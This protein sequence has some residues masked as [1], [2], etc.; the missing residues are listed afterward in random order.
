M[1]RYL[2]VAAV[3]AI[4]AALVSG[5]IQTMVSAYAVQ[6]EWIPP[7]SGIYTGPQFSQ[8]IGDAFRSVASGNKGS[9]APATV[10]G[11]AVDGLPWID[12]TTSFWLKK[13][14]INGGWATEGAY[15]SAGSAWVG[16]IGGGAPASIASSSTVDLGS[17][18]QANVGITGTA[19]ITGFG[20]SAA[21]GI[22]KI[23]R[24]SGALT[25]TNSGS[26]AIPGG[27][28]LVTAAGDRAIVTHLGSGN[29]EIT[30]YTRANGI[31]VD[32]SAVGKIEYGIFESVPANHVAGY[33]QA[34]SR[35]AYPAYVAKVT[36]T[37]TVTRSTGSPS[38]S[39]SLLDGL[40]V[41]MPIEGVGIP[42]GTTIASIGPGTI[43]MSANATSPGS[44][45]ATV[46]L[47]GY[48]S[49]GS[50][51]TV[52]APDCRGRVMAGRDRNDPGSFAN[53]L[54]SSYFGGDSSIF[55]VTGASL[56]S[57]TMAPG[58]L[59][60][61]T[62]A[63]TLTDPGHTHN[64]GGTGVATWRL[65]NLESNA[66][67]PSNSIQFNNGTDGSVAIAGAFTGLTI[68]NAV[69]GS[70]SPT[71]MRTVQPTLIAECVIR[72]TP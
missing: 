37:Q 4:S 42:A 8:L 70:A 55:G 21:A 65:A 19:T 52:G 1:K 23:L 53:R 25:L 6:N 50:I 7:T 29:W 34:L 14:Y 51:S 16:I 30:Q 38:L 63:N 72:V 11:S 12:S 41:G 9:S 40:G 2:G 71:P 35:A 20:S 48:G 26:L 36:R 46:F 44:A 58:N 62:H 18:P 27:F 57:V 69:A 43:V 10:G 67:H 59:I 28:D 45:S 33:A 61:H 32:V 68:N 31:P 56:E 64:F 3:A 17:V 47:T 24:F 54:T 5:A 66:G 49:G 13:R 22:V 60:Q 39:A 15:D